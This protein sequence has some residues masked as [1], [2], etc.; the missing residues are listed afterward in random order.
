MQSAPKPTPLSVTLII[1]K[2]GKLR[3]LLEDLQILY[4][5]CL[6][7]F[8]EMH[9]VIRGRILSYEDG[10]KESLK[11][12]WSPQIGL[13]WPQKLVINVDLFLPV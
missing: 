4:E 2:S 10:L 9:A 11:N 5:V 3:E 7:P 12:C 6:P 13:V 1:P 8:E